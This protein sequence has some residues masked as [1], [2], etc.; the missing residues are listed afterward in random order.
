MSDSGAPAH[1][2]SGGAGDERTGESR[3]A[4]HNQ[5]ATYS[6]VEVQEKSGA[7]LLACSHHQRSIVAIIRALQ[8]SRV[9][10][11]SASSSSGLASSQAS[12]SMVAWLG[13]LKIVAWN[14]GLRDTQFP[15]NFGDSLQKSLTDRFRQMLNLI[16]DTKAD[17]IFFQELSLSPLVVCILVVTG[18][19]GMFFLFTT[20][21][22]SP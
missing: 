14:A 4:Q 20:T 15:L 8:P 3:C 5:P 19:I 13:G 18:T 9:V 17:V 21:S 10:M 16:D 11:A 6:L 12:V 7:S 22:A 1:R 2:A